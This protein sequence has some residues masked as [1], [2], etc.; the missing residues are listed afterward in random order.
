MSQNRADALAPISEDG[1]MKHSRRG[2]LLLYFALLLGQAAS[3]ALITFDDLPF[4]VSHSASWS[5]YGFGELPPGYGTYAGFNWNGTT[6]YTSGQGAVYFNKEAQPGLAAGVVSGN[7]AAFTAW[8]YP[9]VMSLTDGTFTF[10]SV[11]LTAYNSA[12]L[13]LNVQGFRDGVVV[14]SVEVAVSSTPQKFDF[15][16]LNIDAVKFVV[17]GGCHLI[18]DD[19]TVNAP[20]PEPTTMIAG[21]LALLPV[22]ASVL[23][24]FR[25]NRTA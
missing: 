6:G 23:R 24:S 20:V 3:A 17:P 22:G 8:S 15:N 10:N 14:Y 16:L 25:K 1:I 2:T 21:A 4:P 5:E 19:L 7:Q 12:L 11:Y 18:L 9:I 13:A